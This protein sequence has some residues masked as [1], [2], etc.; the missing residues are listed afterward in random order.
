M[1]IPPRQRRRLLGS[2]G[3]SIINTSNAA[4]VAALM[5]KDLLD[6]VRRDADVGHA[7]RGRSAK[8]VNIPAVH[9]GALI[10][11]VLEELSRRGI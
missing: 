5:V 9:T 7:G 3:A 8:V 11:F 2:V 1:L 10:K 6:D 4:L